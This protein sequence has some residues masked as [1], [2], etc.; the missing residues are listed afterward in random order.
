MNEQNPQAVGFYEHM[1]FAA[2]KRTDLDKHGNPY[3]LLY[4]KR[5]SV[6]MADRVAGKIENDDAN[7]L[8]GFEKATNAVNHFLDKR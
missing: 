4:M 7:L 5:G 8:T 2:Y 6:F 3:P 1:G